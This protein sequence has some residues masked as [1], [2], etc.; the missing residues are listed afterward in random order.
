EFVLR[1]RSK[2]DVMIVSE[3]GKGAVGPDLLD[4]LA[5]AH[6]RAPFSWV[7]DP[8]RANFGHYRR[9]TLMKPNREEAAEAAGIEIRDEASLREAGARLLERWEAG[10]VLISRGEEGMALFK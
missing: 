10:A 9:A 8:K 1:Q 4:A 7:I 2:F 6:A 5:E 3:Y